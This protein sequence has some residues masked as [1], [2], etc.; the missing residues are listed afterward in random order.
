[1]PRTWK[2]DFSRR[3]EVGGEQ[4]NV[5]PILVFVEAERLLIGEQVRAKRLGFAQL[6]RCFR[7]F[8]RDL[9]ADFVPP[10]VLDGSSYSA[11]VVSELFLKQIWQ[12]VERQVQPT[13]AIFTVPVG[14]FERYLDW[15]RSLADKLNIPSVRIVDES[16]AAAL[17]YAVKRPGTL[18]LTIDFGGG[19]LDLSLV[20]TVRVTSQQQ[21]VKAEAI[22]KS[23]AFVGGVDIDT[24]IVE[25]YLRKSGF[26][27]AE[28]EEIGWVNLLQVAE[29]LK[30]RLSTAQEAKE[31]WFDD[32]NFL[33][34]ELHL[35]RDELAE[36]LE[37]QQL[38]EQLRQA[39]DEVLAIAL[40]KGIS[41]SAIEQVLLVGRTCQI[42]A[43]QQLVISYF[44]KQRV[45]L[46]KPFEAV[47]HGALALN[48]MVEVDDY[49]RHSYAIRLWKPH[50]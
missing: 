10:K 13:Q 19:T 9:A 48:E 15:F 23:D 14:A 6:E 41:K 5:I 3:F 18:I 2:F 34:H 31:A 1:M 25:H 22:A 26:G 7:A 17:G 36:I 49:L 12:Q 47:T 8:K 50:K 30:I 44:G 45:K 39:I 11:E 4:V 40:T 35:H 29:K 24:W 28:V 16:I 43:V 38:L 33:S 27:R 20:R 42:P 37:N 32:E 21:A 46:D